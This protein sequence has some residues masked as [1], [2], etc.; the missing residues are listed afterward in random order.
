M[1]RGVHTKANVSPLA[2]R[3]GPGRTAGW[4]GSSGPGGEF[5]WSAPDNEDPGRVSWCQPRIAIEC[6]LV[7]GLT[8]FI[9]GLG[10]FKLTGQ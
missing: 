8:T 3:P 10:F 1:A 4:P 6:T 2:E 9:P 5:G 7:S